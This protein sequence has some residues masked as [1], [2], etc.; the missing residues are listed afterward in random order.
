[1]SEVCSNF[2]P[3]QWRKK[4]CKVCGHSQSSHP[5]SEDEEFSNKVH[6][7]GIDNSNGKQKDIKEKDKDKINDKDKEKDKEKD[8]VAR[9]RS[10]IKEKDKKPKEEK[11]EKEKDDK[12]DKK[13]K[14]KKE[15]DKDKVKDKEKEK[16]KDKKEKEKIEKEIKDKEKEKEKEKEPVGRPRSDSASKK[17]NDKHVH[18]GVHN[19]DERSQ[20]DYDVI[21]K[22][23]N[24]L[25]KRDGH[26]K[27]HSVSSMGEPKDDEEKDVLSWISQEEKKKKE[28][29]GKK[30]GRHV[31]IRR[32]PS[33]RER[34]KEKE[35]DKGHLS[36]DEG[37][38]NRTRAQTMES[39]EQVGDYILIDKLGKGAYGMVFKALN[40][41]QGNTV[42][43]KILNLKGASKETV[44]SLEAEISLLQSL[45]HVNI[46]RYIGHI[47]KGKELCIVMEYVENGSLANMVKK[48]GSFPE[49]LAKTYVRKVLVGLVYLHEQGVIHRDIKPDNIL[50]TKDGEV[51]LADFGVSTKLNSLKTD[52]NDDAMPAG[53]PYYMAPEVIEFFGAKPESDVWSLGCTIIELLRGE[54]PYFHNDPFS[55]MYKMVE[56]EHPPLPSVFQRVVQIS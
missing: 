14:E 34:D 39:R 52:K 45:D 25:P 46:V 28:E 44:E 20:S 17:K 31:E 51:K 27:K 16:D 11:K 56:D 54:P 29:E 22:T 48:Y 10:E 50:I 1:M 53:T 30:K 23:K 15:K 38:N 43:I 6:S 7:D 4:K 5:N 24:P 37:R 55:A 19:R 3:S 8:K 12:K 21:D 41:Y 9:P 13:E 49:T 2:Q 42:A 18:H 35:K 36:S 47:T 32:S 33:E 26:Q 40:L